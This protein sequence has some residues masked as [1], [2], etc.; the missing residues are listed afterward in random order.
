MPGTLAPLCSGTKDKGDGDG[1]KPESDPDEG[2]TAESGNGETACRFMGECS[3]E[4]APNDELRFVRRTGAA[5]ISVALAA[6]SATEMGGRLLWPDSG[7]LRAG[8]GGGPSC[9]RCGRDGMES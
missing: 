9:R 2:A 4:T 6:S 8:T 7:R 1:A 5:S 3:S